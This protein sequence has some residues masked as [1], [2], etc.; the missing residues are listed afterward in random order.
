[1]HYTAVKDFSGKYISVCVC[2]CGLLCSAPSLV[3][4]CLRQYWSGES[5]RDERS[6]GTTLTSHQT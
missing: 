5:E 3:A 6:H 4:S 2:V 1:M